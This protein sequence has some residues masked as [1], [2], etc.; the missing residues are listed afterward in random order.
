MK[1][2]YHEISGKWRVESGEWKRGQSLIE[3][4]VAMGVVAMLAISLV[5]T[6]LITQRSARSAR[7]NTQATN[8]AQQSIEQMRVFR[9]RKGYGTLTNNPPAQCWKIDTSA[10]MSKPEVWALSNS[11]PE[12]ISLNNTSFSRSITIENGTDPD[13]KKITVTVAWQDS[14]GPQSVRSVTLL[15]NCVFSSPSG[16]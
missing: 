10:D 9:D 8:L 13:Q 7:N 11:C 15:S 3:V 2:L 4:L 6:T 1:S 16:C 5:T 12:T 14:S